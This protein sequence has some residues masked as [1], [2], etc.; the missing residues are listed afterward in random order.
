VRDALYAESQAG[1]PM[2]AASGLTVRPRTDANASLL[3]TTATLHLSIDLGWFG[4]ITW[5]A[6]L[7]SIPG[8]TLA[9]YDS[10]SKPGGWGEQ[11]TMRIGTGASAG[12]PMKNPDV[13]TH[14]PG[15]DEMSAFGPGNDVDTCLAEPPDTR[16]SPPPCNA[17]PTTG[18]TPT[19][20]TC[21]YSYVQV[22]GAVCADIAGAAT[23]MGG[24]GPM[25]ECWLEYLQLLCESTSYQSG[26]LVSHVLDDGRS[27]SLADNMAAL[28]NVQNTCVNAAVPKTSD[29][30]ADAANAKAFVNSFFHMAICDASGRPLGPSEI[31]GPIGDP[32]SAPAPTPPGTCK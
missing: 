23:T 11:A 16:P 1:A 2:R 21:V 22:A 8:V 30:T 32:T 15:K 10:D 12:D 26:A 6:Q 7:F 18:A 27:G 3:D 31:L 14:L 13:H 19:A 25:A 28:G 9:S 24:S 29:K 4:T 20:N 5:D 17:P